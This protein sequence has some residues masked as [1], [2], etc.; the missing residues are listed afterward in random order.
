[1]V[2]V[3]YGNYSGSALYDINPNFPVVGSVLQI[4]ILRAR[5]SD[6]FRNYND[7]TII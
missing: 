5:P 2:C 7:Y 6:P 4:L 1:M 3:P